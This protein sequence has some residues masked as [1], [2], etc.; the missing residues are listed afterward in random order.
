MQIKDTPAREGK[1]KSLWLGAFGPTAAD[2]RI[3]P[4]RLWMPILFT[5]SIGFTRGFT[6]GLFDGSSDD[7][8]T[9]EIMIAQQVILGVLVLGFA[10]SMIW[11]TWRWWMALDELERKIEGIVAVAACVMAWIAFITVQYGHEFLGLDFHEDA[12]L[13]VPALAYLLLRAIVRW[14]L[15]AV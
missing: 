3:F 15:R 11:L 14:H 6:E 10:G 8:V 13:V 5:L 4:L 1:S 7:V 12:I 9:P 2:K